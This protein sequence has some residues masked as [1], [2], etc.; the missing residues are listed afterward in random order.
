MDTNTYQ[1]VCQ[2]KIISNLKIEN[3]RIIDLG[4]GG[5]RWTALLASKAAEVIGVD[6][7]T[8][9][10]KRAT[11]Q[12]CNK[13][14]M[15]PG[16]VSFKL[17]DFRDQDQLLSLGYFDLVTAF[18]VI[19]RV[20]DVFGF[21]RLVSGLGDRFFTEW[22]CPVFPGMRSI[23]LALHSEEQFIDEANIGTVAKGSKITTYGSYGFWDMSPRAVEVALRREG[24]EKSSLLGLARYNDNEL[25][26]VNEAV[27]NQMKHFL[28][29]LYRSRTVGTSLLSPGSN[30][31]AY[32]SF[33]KTGKTLL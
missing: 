24:F 21:F 7:R 25:S 30:W 4:C 28:R 15:H 22:R 9:A 23:S 31:R 12:F 27:R 32:M 17:V 13:N 3:L 11:Q 16:N 5:G 33:A 8:E 1:R 26:S 29:S 10:I 6:H 2:E 14:S 18:G 19:H 20:S